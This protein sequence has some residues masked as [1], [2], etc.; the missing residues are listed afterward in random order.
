MQTY[1]EKIHRNLNRKP[2]ILASLELLHRSGELG[3]ARAYCD[4][5]SAYMYGRGGVE[6]DKK[7]AMYYYELAAIGGHLLGRLGIAGHEEDLGNMDRALKH[8]M[9]GARCGDSFCLKEILRFYSAGHATR[10]DYAN[11]LRA[12]QAFVADIKSDQRDEAAAACDEE[13]HY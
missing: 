2:N 10:E 1:A 13:Y 11:A 8:L 3:S 12:Y 7:K 4:I 5:G 6:I 9:I